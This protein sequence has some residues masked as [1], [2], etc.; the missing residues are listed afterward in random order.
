M[1]DQNSQ[2]FLR[3]LDKKLWTAA[4]SRSAAETAGGNLRSNLDAAV[5]SRAERDRSRGSVTR[6]VDAGAS[7]RHAVLG[8]R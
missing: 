4:D 1:A 8:L 7:I 5:Y 6:R 3:E 2:D